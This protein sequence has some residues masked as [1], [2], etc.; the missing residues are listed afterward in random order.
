MDGRLRILRWAGEG[1]SAQSSNVLSDYAPA[2]IA[3]E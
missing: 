3:A 1:A 2:G